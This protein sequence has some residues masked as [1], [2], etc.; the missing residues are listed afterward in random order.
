M[1][2]TFFISILIS[3]I[4]S[5][6]CV[7]GGGQPTPITPT[8]ND[9][10]YFFIFAGE[11]NSG[12]MALNSSATSDELL[13]Q[14][15]VQI[16]N[17]NTYV[18]E[19]LDIGTNNLI[20]H[21]GLSNG[22]LHGW[23]L[24]LANRVK[25]NS[26]FYGDTVFLVKTGQG[27]SQANNWRIL[28]G[29][30]CDSTSYLTYFGYFYNRVTKAD[31]MLQA[32]R[33]RKVI[34]MSIGINDQLGGTNVDSFKVEM[35]RNIRNF[36]VV[37]RDTTPIILTKFFGTVTRFDNAIDSIANHMGLARVYTV[38]G[39]APLIDTYHWNYTGMKTIA[40]RLLDKLEEIF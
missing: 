14:S 9:Y 20:G 28:C 17:N 36:R 29:A 15:Q 24:Q 11:S 37:T 27:G 16:L 2:K 26:A 38:D 7:C 31:S 19:D 3:A 4:I 22:T 10:K 13:P 12:G 34:F 1:K 30:Y 21:T 18:F 39:N 33:L 8:A 23:E 35:V 25:A 6:A 5:M 40:D 32:K